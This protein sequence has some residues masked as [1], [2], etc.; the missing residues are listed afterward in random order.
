MSDTLRLILAAVVVLAVVSAALAP[1]PRRRPPAEWRWALRWLLPATLLWAGCAHL[2]KWS[3]D[4]VKDLLVAFVVLA[5]LEVWLLRY[6]D[7][8]SGTR[9]RTKPPKRQRRPAGRPSLFR[10]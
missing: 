2:L 1:A 7:P 3:P 6:R 10:R 8:A 4:M 5:C 9:A